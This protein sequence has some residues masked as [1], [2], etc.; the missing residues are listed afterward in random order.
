MKGDASS[1]K[2]S[3]RRPLTLRSAADLLR[4]ARGFQSVSTTTARGVNKKAEEEKGFERR[5]NK[6]ERS[7]ARTAK[8]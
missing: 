4:K 2:G 3:E 5:R 6:K 1:T 7:L 8:E